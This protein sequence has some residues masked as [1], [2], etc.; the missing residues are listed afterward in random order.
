LAG[1]YAHWGGG[2][3]NLSRFVFD[4][5]NGRINQKYDD[6]FNDWVNRWGLLE[7]NGVN[8][9]FTWSNNQVIPILAKLDRIFVST[10]WERALTLAKVTTLAKG[11]SDHNPLLIDLGDNCS[12]SKKKFI[13]EKWW[14]K[15]VDFKEVV[16]KA[17]G[18]ECPLAD[19]MDWWQIR[20]R[21]FRRMV[22][23][24]TSNVVAELNKKKQYVAAEYNLLDI[25]SEL[26][27]FDRGERNR[28]RTLARELEQI[29]A[30]EEIKARQRSRDTNILEGDRNIAY[31]QVVANC[32]NMKKRIEGLMGPEGMK[33]EN[34][35]ILKIAADYYRSLFGKESRG[36]FSLQ[37][38]FWDTAE[39]VFDE[40]NAALQEPF[41]EK[42][43]RDAVFS[44]YPES[45]L[46]PDG[47]P[48]LFYQKIW[49][50]VKEDFLSLIASFQEGN[51]DLFRLN[52]ATLTLIP[53]VE[54]DVEMKAFWPISL[55]NCSFKVFSKLLTIRLES[56]CQ[57]IVAKEQCAFIR[58]RYILES[59][60]IAHELV[61][62]VHKAKEPGI[63][64]KLDYENAYDRV[65][66]DF[67]LE[68][69]RLRGFGE[70]WIGWIKK[71]VL[72]GSVCVMPNGEES[73]SFK[74]GKYLRQGDPISPSC[75]I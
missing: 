38:D 37:Y 2:G 31:F 43:V 50:V 20:I 71:I 54:N 24:W 16:V 4:K 28:V 6:C 68:I 58:G 17:W 41:S 34:H 22:R 65:N 49:E 36:H 11:I 40:E 61:H 1:A 7:L 52:F 9:R 26:M 60:V 25:E 5:S 14:L 57:R 67:L 13:F 64:L 12:F 69:L 75:L 39:L 62:S 59:V 18:A 53:K 74:T 27:I 72:G 56:V 48:F 30:L 19:P 44:S 32:R 21:T 70:K 46:G 63:I 45:A 23:G 42:E 35:D 8:R 66:M 33:C 51:L 55:L 10:D 29:W 15:R 47:L 3:F 73:A